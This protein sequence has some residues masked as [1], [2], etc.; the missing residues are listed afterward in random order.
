MFPFYVSVHRLFFYQKVYALT[1]PCHL[2]PNC[3]CTDIGSLLWY[4]DCI[5][6]FNL[7]HLFWLS[8]L[9][10]ALGL[11]MWLALAVGTTVSWTWAKTWKIAYISSFLV[12]HHENMPSLTCWR[13]KTTCIDK[14]TYLEK[15]WVF[16]GEAI[17][18]RATPQTTHKLITDAWGS[19]A[20]INWAWLRLSEITAQWTHILMIHK[21]ILL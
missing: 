7:H 6:G 16:W 15:S 1:C 3:Q 2:A 4:I 14:I 12:S 8:P 20:M 17:Q 10:L 18:G 13:D 21:W 19:S 11:T 9:T 5:N